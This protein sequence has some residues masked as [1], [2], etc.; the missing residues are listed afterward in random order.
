MSWPQAA[1]APPR[2]S[3]RPPWC[4]PGHIMLGRLSAA[5]RSLLSVPCPVPPPLFPALLVDPPWHT[6]CMRP[7]QGEKAAQ[8]FLSE[9][10]VRS[11]PRAL[12]LA[13]RERVL[14]A[15][16]LSPT[17]NLLSSM[18]LVRTGAVRACAVRCFG[19]A[20][21]P[22]SLG[23]L[24]LCLRCLLGPAAAAPPMLSTLPQ[25]RPRRRTGCT[26][27]RWRVRGCG[28]TCCVARSWCLCRPA[29][30]QSA[31]SW[32]RP[33]NW[34]CAAWSSTARSR[35][36]RQVW[37]GVFGGGGWGRRGVVWVSVFTGADGW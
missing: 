22:A 27:A 12:S 29:T 23:C 32:R 5:Q 18:P 19:L 9:A 1:C 21:L 14:A 7:L 3:S 25:R 8:N 10:V 26:A 16:P 36:A 34:A 31:S 2:R 37:M 15:T 28:A 24:Q 4:V 6:A 13:E 30:P 35:G 17:L 33:R 20:S 11:L